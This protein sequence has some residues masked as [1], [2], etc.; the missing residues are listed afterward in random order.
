MWYYIWTSLA[1]FV[2]LLLGYIIARR[3]HSQKLDDLYTE[4]T[5]DE[6]IL[7][8]QIRIKFKNLI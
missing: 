3:F 4:L 2:G 5:Q 7:F 8:D 1:L 6:K